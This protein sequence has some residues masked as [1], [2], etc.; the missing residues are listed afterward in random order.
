MGHRSGVVGE[1]G[2][3]AVA[4]H[5]GSE[6]KWKRPSAAAQPE[7]PSRQGCYP[8]RQAVSPG[9]ANR[10]ATVRGYLVFSRAAS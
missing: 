10:G 8:G 7:E 6:K 9:R 2:G 3:E 5:L 1:G 4:A